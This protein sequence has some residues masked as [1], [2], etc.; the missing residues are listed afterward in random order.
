[1]KLSEVEGGKKLKLSDIQKP[2]PVRASVRGGKPMAENQSSRVQQPKPNPA[3]QYLAGQVKDRA[4]ALRA[5]GH[6]AL[7]MPLGILDTAIDVG[8]GLSRK[9]G[10]NKGIQDLQSGYDKW[11]A[12]REAKYQS[13]V[14]DSIASYGGATVG[15]V[16]PWTVGA[17]AKALQYAG[18]AGEIIPTAKGALGYASRFGQRAVGGGAQGLLASMAMPAQDRESATAIGATLGAA[19]P[20]ASA[21]VSPAAKFTWDYLFNP[22]IEAGR[23]LAGKFGVTSA[24]LPYLQGADGYYPGHVRTTAEALADTPL[25]ARAAAAQKELG[26]RP[27]FATAEEEMRVANDV[28]AANVIRQIAGTPEQQA[29]A[30][31]AR[32]AATDPFYQQR[33]NNPTRNQRYGNAWEAIESVKGK[34][35]S[36]AE[37]ENM[38]NAQRIISR[39]QRGT[40]DEATAAAELK[41]IQTKSQTGKKAIAQA[42]SSISENMAKGTGLIKFVTDGTKAIPDTIK[43]FASLVLKDLENNVDDAGRI[44]TKK[45]HQIKE[46]LNKKIFDMKKGGTTFGAD[47]YAWI[48]QLQTRIANALEKTVPG[49][50]ANNATYAQLSG[51]INTQRAAQQIIDTAIDSPNAYLNSGHQ[52]RITPQLINRFLSKDDRARYGMAEDARTALEGIQR[53]GRETA[54]TASALRRAGSDTDLNAMTSLMAKYGRGAATAGGGA[55]IGATYGGVPGAVVGALLGG[56]LGALESRVAGLMAKGTYD[57]KEAAKMIEAYLRRYP[58]ADRAKILAKYPAIRAVMAQQSNQEQ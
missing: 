24:E 22:S 19:L 13:E 48:T 16:L 29:A 8:A 4:D 3:V 9:F 42:E 25:S 18:R 36:A 26:N 35:M 44:S 12:E 53:A 40:M 11:L 23:R 41:A 43:A 17:P 54:G 28:A 5:V 55:T 2:K 20:V 7:N 39:V 38:E 46:S 14:P 51:P 52:A 45:L 21:T 37:F 15:S 1:M 30:L 49:Y 58:P 6:H 34:R 31:D 47:E 33:I 56:G 10:G 27:Q 32:K 50:K 57:S